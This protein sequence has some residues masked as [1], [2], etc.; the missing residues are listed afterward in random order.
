MHGQQN[1]KI[2]RNVRLAL[3]SMCTICDN[4]YGIIESAESGT[5]VFV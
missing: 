3:I 5:Q 2:C 4:A 1:I